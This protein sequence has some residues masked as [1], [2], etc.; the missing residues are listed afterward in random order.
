MLFQDRALACGMHALAFSQHAVQIAWTL[1]SGVAWLTLAHHLYY[2]HIV[3]II[4]IIII[5]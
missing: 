4:I 2:I 5:I 3:I 1:L